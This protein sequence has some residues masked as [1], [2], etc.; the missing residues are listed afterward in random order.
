MP[1]QQTLS[2]TPATDRHAQILRAAMFCFA[3]CGFHQTSMHDVAEEAG[4]SVGLIYRYFASKEAVI[5][6]LA[7]EHK[8]ELDALLERARSAPTL[9][10]SLEILLTAHC[11]EDQPQLHCAFVVDLFAEAGR[12]PG[13]ASLVRDVLETGMAGVT[14]VIA[15]APEMQDPPHGLTPREVTELIFAAARGSMMRDV[16]EHAEVSATE[17]RERQL[18]VVRQLWRLLFDHANQPAL[19]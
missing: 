9:L 7:E 6:A 16:L 11:C 1:Q 15:R 13:I 10:D 2:D 3:K 14:D 17:R 8:Q 12:N 19:A 18:K 4:I 5:A